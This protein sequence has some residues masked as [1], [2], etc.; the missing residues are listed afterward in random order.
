M[1]DGVGESKRESESDACRG[2]CPDDYGRAVAK[3]GVAQICEGVGFEAI[4]QSA[5]VALSDIAIHYICDLG[6]SAS[7]YA[8]LAGRSE[9][10]LF[11]IVKGLEDLGSSSDF[12]GYLEVDQSFGVME[13]GVLKELAEFVGTLEETPFP[14]SIPQFPVVK[15]PRGI[16]SF[17][18]MGE[19]PNGKHIPTWLPAFPDLHTYIQ[20]PVW[21][22]RK[23]D[24]RTDKVEQ[25]RQRRKAERSLLSLQQRLLSNS[26][27]GPSGSGNYNV[28]AGKDLG[29]NT[30]KNAFLAPPLPVGEKEVSTVL[31][32]S[33]LTNADAEKKEVSVLETFSPAI[34]AMKGAESDSVDLYRRVVSERRPVV[35]FKLKV[36]KKMLVEDLD[37]NL[38]SRA[39]DRRSSSIGRD[40]EKDD[41]RRRV[42]LILRQSMENPQ[43][44]LQT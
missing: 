23:T 1:S 42:E 40:D 16:P 24:P 35:H 34:D 5:L 3:V 33:E 44:L 27:T 38:R 18:H 19:V 11:D 8:S 28:T 14:L 32:P 43:D 41:K 13:S 12:S 37:V 7:L 26:L 21:N 10:S 17:L 6:K 25:V 22:E 39:N 29:A 15:C 36:G 2:A 4:K 31:L 9:V 20:S 30:N